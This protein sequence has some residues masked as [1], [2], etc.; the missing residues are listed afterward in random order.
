MCQACLVCVSDCIEPLTD[1]ELAERAV[2]E[3]YMRLGFADSSVTVDGDVLTIEERARYRLSS[4]DIARDLARVRECYGNAGYGMVDISQMQGTAEH[5]TYVDL[6]FQ[7]T[8]GPRVTVDSVKVIGNWRVSEA[9]IRRKSVVAPGQVY[10]DA[11]IRQT[12]HAL[13]ATGRF[14]IVE[15]GWRQ[16]KG[17]SDRAEVTIAVK[18]STRVRAAFRELI[19]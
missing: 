1:A 16:T 11:A 2:R 17:T 3:L 7:I 13:E 12:Q 9:E 4:Q 15:V 10:S 8:R 14:D 19:E 5:L 18:E 6:L